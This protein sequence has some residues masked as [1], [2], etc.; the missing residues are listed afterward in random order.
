MAILMKGPD[1]AEG[2]K[3]SLTAEVESLK[4]NG[5]TPT[6]AVIRVGSREDDMSYERGALKRC[7]A[8]GIS[9]K[10]IELPPDTEQAAFDSAFV[11]VNNDPSVHG[12]LLFRPLPRHLS[13]DFARRVIDPR[14]DVDGM[15]FVNAARVFAGEVGTG[16]DTFAPCTPCAVMETLS[17]YGVSLEGKRAVIVGRSMVVGRSLAMLMLAANAT[18]TICLQLRLYCLSVDIDE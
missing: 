6:L 16:H 13:D 15:S 8:L 10:V 4:D 1:V 7:A 11:K 5:I 3:A 9:A 12:I 18:V 14:K 17:H 2:M